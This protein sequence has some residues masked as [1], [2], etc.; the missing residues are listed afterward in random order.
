AVSRRDTKDFLEIGGGVS[1]LP[2]YDDI[3][4]FGDADRVIALRDI[5]VEIAPLIGAACPPEKRDTVAAPRLGEPAPEPVRHMGVYWSRAADGRLLMRC[6]E[7]EGLKLP[8]SDTISRRQVFSIAGLLVI[9][10]AAGQDAPQ[11]WE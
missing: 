2:Y 5:L 9:I 11:L 6:V 10:Y 1:A 3:A 4:L 7:H 8:G